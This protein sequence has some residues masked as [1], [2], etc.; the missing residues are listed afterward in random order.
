ME[1]E[2]RTI[3]G[4]VYFG[5]TN[6]PA[7]DIMVALTNSEDLSMDDA[8]T[9]FNGEFAFRG[10]HPGS[11]TLSIDAQGYEKLSV[12]LDLSFTSSKG[13]ILRLR[14]T[15]DDAQPHGKNGSAVSVHMLS[16]PAS[17]RA[18][19]DSGRQKLY[20]DKNPEGSVEEFQRA[21]AISPGFYE[22]YEQMGLA[23]LQL[24][25]PE[26][27]EKAASKSI[28]L[29]KDK[30]AAADFDLGAMLMNRRQFADGERIVR[31]GLELDPNAWIGHYELGRALFY[32]KRVPDALKSA[33]Q[34]RALQ[35]NAA[36]T[37]RLLALI[38]TSQ[39]DEPALLQDLD[40]YIKLDPDSAMGLRAKQLRDK[41]ASA[42]PEDRPRIQ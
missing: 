4:N 25:K 41:V 24:E 12:S 20:H 33:E 34:A 35:P 28:E 17:A 22:A 38:H 6:K 11:Y 14:P 3:E 2:R 23:Y 26:D 9:G 15:G 42:S 36:I 19:F 39:H 21:V 1:R 32:E 13:N 30:Y 31:H 37:Y 29:S 8:R 16:L 10:L 40:T 27:A 5:E 7:P 18:A